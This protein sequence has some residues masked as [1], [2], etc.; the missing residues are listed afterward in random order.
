MFRSSMER[1]CCCRLLPHSTARIRN[2]RRKSS[3]FFGSLKEI[4]K[5]L[6]KHLPPAFKVRV[7][8]FKVKEYAGDCALNLKKKQF[9]IRIHKDLNPDSAV[10]VLLHEWAH[11]LSWAYDETIDE[12]GPEW[13]V[14]YSRVYSCWLEHC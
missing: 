2:K 7:T 12:H 14:A 10:L 4:V 6:R 8:R 5:G 11:A 13:G 3:K 1:V 9:S